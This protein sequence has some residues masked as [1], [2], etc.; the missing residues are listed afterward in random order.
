MRNSNIELLRIVAMF[1][2]VLH[3][4]SVH[5]TWPEPGS[6]PL[7]SEAMIAVLSFGGKIGVNIFVLITGYFMMTSRFRLKSLLRVILETLFYSYILVILFYLITPGNM[8]AGRIHKALM[9]VVSGEYWFITNFIA[10]M[11]V[12]PLL[13]A[14]YGRIGNS[15]LAKAVAIGFVMFSILP[16]L[17]KFD[18]LAS[19]LL[20]FIFLYLLGGWVRVSCGQRRCAKLLDPLW[21]AQKCGGFVL[22]FAS[23]AFCLATIVAAVF[24]GQRYGLELFSPTYFVGQNMVPALLAGVGLLVGFSE[25][26]LGSIKI[27][28][29][30][31]KTTLGIYLIHDNP[32]VRL[33]LWKMFAPIAALS[34]GGIAFWGLVSA[35]AVFCICSAVDYLR[36]RVVEAPLMSLVSRRFGSVIDKVDAWFNALNEPGAAQVPTESTGAGKRGLL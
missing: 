21:Y 25:R 1:L 30:V 28:N 36:M 35:G 2:I 23:I 29:E 4:F 31:A 32:F 6:F 9:P 10:L 15:G 16:T 24:L 34:W 8:S 12:S 3:H 27:I 26:N 18:P 7:S 20:W 22:A 33:W 17:T 13:N 11:F 5:G 14:L 19:N